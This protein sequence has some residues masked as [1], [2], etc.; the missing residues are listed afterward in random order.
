M[1]QANN[2]AIESSQIN[3]SGVLLTTGGGTGLSTVGTNG[4]VLT[5][6]G[7]TLSWVT[8]TTT[9]PGGSTGQVQYNNGT[10][11]AGSAN[12]YWDG[13]NNRLGIGTSSPTSPLQIVNSSVGQVFTLTSSS[14][15]IYG[16]ATDG[17]ISVYTGGVLTGIGGFVG[18]SSAHPYIFR[19]NNTEVMRLDSSGSLG[20]NTTVPANYGKFSVIG[21]G[22]GLNSAL[23]VGNTQSDGAQTPANSGLMFGQTSNAT[24][25]GQAAI[26]PIGSGG[27]VG[28]L[29]F[30]TSNGG[31][32]GGTFAMSEKMRIDNTGNLLVGLT[33]F[34]GVTGG[35]SGRVSIN[36]TSGQ[37]GLRIFNGT[38]G[39]ANPVQFSNTTGGEVGTIFVTSTNTT[40][41]TSSDYRL[42]EN[43]KP[44]IGALDKISLLKPCTY[45]WKST[46]I[47]G[48]GFIAHELQEVVPDAVCGEKDAVHEDGSIKPQ[49]I[50][51]SVLVATLTAAIQ[52]LKAEFD[53][54][55]AAHP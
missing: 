8:P 49:G 33:Q 27:F 43:V 53:E 52:E 39:N 17:T 31:G 18:T 37:Y 45:T 25:F 13:T 9:S 48:Q 24:G 6:N 3:S 28:M 42:K 7:T 19:T 46:G 36:F 5:S 12:F 35:A 15:N 4:Q 38:G 26:W 51:T 22:S 23:F 20:V 2:V 41:N 11:F 14:A 54:Y 55:K 1:T 34:S 10:T 21:V 30:G 32:T 29:A 47:D 16:L 40:Y 50:D 44:M